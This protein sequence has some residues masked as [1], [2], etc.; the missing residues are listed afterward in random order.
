M[1][2]MILLAGWLCLM[3]TPAQAGHKPPGILMRIY[4]QTAGEGLPETEAHTIQVPPNNETIQIRALPEVT[5]AELIDVH[6]DPSGNVYF[7]F[8][9]EGRVNLD[10]FT[11]ENQ[12]KIMVVM[13]NGYIIYAPTIDV[14]LSNGELMI[15]HPLDPQVI[16]ILQD[17]AK[18][19]VEKANKT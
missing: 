3:V 4:V 8:N 13:L 2:W 16:Q 6:T 10:A 18:R 9:H 7:E 12:G 17:M 1:R 15:P 19:N 5:E 11:G 14:Q